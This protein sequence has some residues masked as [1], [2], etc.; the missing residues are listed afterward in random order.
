MISEW[1]WMTVE[2][3]LKILEM[4][5]RFKETAL[6]DAWDQRWRI[7]NG[8]ELIFFYLGGHRCWMEDDTAKF[9]IFKGESSFSLGVQFHLHQRQRVRR[10]EVAL[11]VP[12]GSSIRISIIHQSAFGPLSAGGGPQMALGTG[13]PIPFPLPPFPLHRHLNDDWLRFDCNSCRLMVEPDGGFHNTVSAAAHR[14]HCP[15][16]TRRPARS[17]PVI[18]IT[19]VWSIHAPLITMSPAGRQ[20]INCFKWQRADGAPH[21]MRLNTESIGEILIDAFIGR[22]GS[23]SHD[24]FIPPIPKVAGDDS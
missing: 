1:W 9:F 11:S 14:W 12:P 10:R 22:F 3:F 24:A 17:I 23:W 2:R 4:M 8:G 15:H 19:P 18:F 6:F 16:A 13:A 20:S 7:S 5:A 21:L